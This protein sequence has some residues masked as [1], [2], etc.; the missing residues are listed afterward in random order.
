MKNSTI[1][2]TLLIAWATILLL[3]CNMYAQT[4]VNIDSLG[5]TDT[6]P[7]REVLSVKTNLL[8]YGVYMPGYN[9]WC[10]MPN[11]AVEYYPKKGHFTFGASLD[12]PWW[13]DYDAHKYFQIRNYQVEGRYYLKGAK[14]AN[15]AHEA[16]EANGAYGA[17]GA[18]RA[19]GAYEA[20]GAYKAHGPYRGWYLQGYVHGGVFGICFDADRGW[21][22]EGIGAGVGAGYVMPVS[23]NGHW[24]L[25]FALQAGYFRCKYDPY[26]YENPVDPSYKDN[27][28]YYKWTLEPSLFK[29]RQYRWNWIGPTRIGVTLTYDLLYKRQQ[30]RGV[31]FKDYET[32]G[33]T[34][35]NGTNE[36]GER[37]AAL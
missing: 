31:S 2:R 37:R 20:N 7:R 15:E 36:L 13:Q 35:T 25:E 34:G 8:F 30:K 22:G 14:G 33:T 24:R 1:I 32:Y 4:A 3:P 12:L 9:R 5:S 23:R 18:N 17:N 6:L 19:N 26:Q 11:V 29:K 28:Y 21:V 27:L 10:P 16:N